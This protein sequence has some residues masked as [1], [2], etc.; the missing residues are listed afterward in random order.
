[1]R[2]QTVFT[3]PSSPVE[4][5]PSRFRGRPKGALSS[6]QMLANPLIRRSGR[7]GER[8]QIGVGPAPLIACHNGRD[9]SRKRNRSTLFCGH[10]RGDGAGFA[11][12]N[13]CRR[14][15]KSFAT[16]N[17]GESHAVMKTS[18]LGMVFGLL[19]TA[20]AFTATAP[21]PQRPAAAAAPAAPAINPALSYPPRASTHR[22]KLPDNVPGASPK[23][24]LT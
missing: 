2:S 20:V 15:V 18:F 13:P 8:G 11:N 7:A 5:G 1:M 3:G 9:T 23:A 22:F 10:P 19:A 16:R 24:S 17:L 4:E 6:P 21:N 12:K 14:Q